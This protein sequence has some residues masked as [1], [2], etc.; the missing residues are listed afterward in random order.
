MAPRWRIN[1]TRRVPTTQQC[2]TRARAGGARAGR[3]WRRSVRGARRVLG[4]S[5]SSRRP[6]GPSRGMRSQP[7]RRIFRR[8]FRERDRHRPAELDVVEFRVV[9]DS[10]KIYAVADGARRAHFQLGIEGAHPVGEAARR[11]EAERVVERSCD[12]RL[13]HE[14]ARE[15]RVILGGAAVGVSVV[16][17]VDDL[18]LVACLPLLEGFTDA[19]RDMQA[20]L[21]G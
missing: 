2:E 1:S 7:H 8:I 14:R 21:E 13:A 15:V 10:V 18:D 11:A 12:V 16:H 3:P 20:C 19:K 4:R 17:V 9:V 5:A 6:R